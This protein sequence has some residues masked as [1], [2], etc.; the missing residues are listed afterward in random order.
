MVKMINL[1][2]SHYLRRG[3]KEAPLVKKSVSFEGTLF[4]FGYLIRALKKFIPL[5]TPTHEIRMQNFVSWESIAIE[6]SDFQN[7]IRLEIDKKYQNFQ[8]L[9]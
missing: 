3:K 8:Q 2:P 9:Q 7:I 5:N 6:V 1:Y 4:M